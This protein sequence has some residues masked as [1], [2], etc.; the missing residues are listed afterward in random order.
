MNNPD[1]NTTSY[2]WLVR[3]P[4]RALREFATDKEAL[5]A[6]RDEEEDEEA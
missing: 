1:P 3:L 4:S 5:D 6:V 2:G